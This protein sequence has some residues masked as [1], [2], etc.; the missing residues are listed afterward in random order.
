MTDLLKWEPAP[1][2]GGFYGRSG[3]L[4]VAMALCDMRGQ[5]V[6]TINA[7]FMNYIGEA[8]GEAADMGA[9]KAAAEANWKIWLDHAGLAPVS[10]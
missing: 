9:A 7:V 2:G 4:V 10:P 3:K 1:G 8:R 6:F 5:H